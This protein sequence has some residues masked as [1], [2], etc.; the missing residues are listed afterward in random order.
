MLL[1][2]LC[3]GLQSKTFTYLQVSCITLSIL[4]GSK[5]NWVIQ[6]AHIKSFNS[7]YFTE[8][9]VEQFAR[10]R[11]ETIIRINKEEVIALETASL[12]RPHKLDNSSFSTSI[13]T[14]G[15]CRK[16]L[17]LGVSGYLAKQRFVLPTGRPPGDH[18]G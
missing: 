6:K 11:P 9:S 4:V 3:A 5:R 18:P 12:D 10:Y 13:F 15:L 14:V 7:R 16:S 1:Q 2:P 17:T 8:K